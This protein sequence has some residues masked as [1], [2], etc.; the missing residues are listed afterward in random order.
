LVVTLPGVHAD[1]SLEF[2]TTTSTGPSM[3]LA[4]N[5]G[6]PQELNT[7]DM[8]IMQAEMLKKSDWAESV[9]IL[10]RGKR[11]IVPKDS[12]VPAAGLTETV[13][14]AGCAAVDGAGGS[15]SVPAAGMTETVVVAGCAAVDGAGGSS[16]V[17]AAGLAAA[18]GG[19]VVDAITQDVDI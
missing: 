8:P 12:S 1:S 18:D 3:A 9:E 16:S 19:A 4:M 10:L 6:P 11:A 13:V 14:V 7:E 2:H 5:W 15:S 17:P